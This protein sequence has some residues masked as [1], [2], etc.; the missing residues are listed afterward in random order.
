MDPD[1]WL[2]E[3]RDLIKGRDADDKRLLRWYFEDMETW[4]RR[5]GFGPSVKAWG[6]RWAKAVPTC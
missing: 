6:P 2:A 5:G 1:K 4:L 3:V